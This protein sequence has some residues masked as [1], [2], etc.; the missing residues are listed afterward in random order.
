MKLLRVKAIKAAEI[1]SQWKFVLDNHILTHNKI[2]V[3]LYF[4]RDIET[5]LRNES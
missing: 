4:V 3:S 5:T 2:S 1:D